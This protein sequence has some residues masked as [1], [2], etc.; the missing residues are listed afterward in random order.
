[1]PLLPAATPTLVENI[2]TAYRLRPSFAAAD[3]STYQFLPPSLVLYNSPLAPP[4]YAT[5]VLYISI[6]CGG[7]DVVVD[8]DAKMVIVVQ[9][10]PPSR[11]LA[12]KFSDPIT[13]IAKSL[14]AAIE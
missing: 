5:L 7:L 12:A 4:Q 14:T 8:P 6:A 10:V 1:M 13:I 11:L 9:V 3:V 2:L